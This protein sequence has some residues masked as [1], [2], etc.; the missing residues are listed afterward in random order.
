MNAI[1]LYNELRKTINSPASSTR[2]LVSKTG[3]WRC[4]DE[5]EFW[6]SPDGGVCLGGTSLGTRVIDCIDPDTAFIFTATIDL[7]TASGTVIAVN[8]TLDDQQ[9]YNNRMCSEANPQN[10]PWIEVNPV[11]S[12]TEN[13]PIGGQMTL[14]MTN[15]IASLKIGDAVKIIADSGVVISANIVSKNNTTK[16]VVLDATVDL[17]SETNAKLTTCCGLYFQDIIDRI[18]EETGGASD[19]EGDFDG[20]CLHSVFELSD[21][22]VANS[23]HPMIDGRLLR[24]GTAGTRASLSDGAANQEIVFTSLVLNAFGND[25]S[26][27]ILNVA[28]TAVTV[29][30]SWSDIKIS[31][32]NNS[33]TATVNDI[34]AA[35][36]A[37]PSAR[38]LVQ[39]TTGGGDGSG[40]A[41]ALAE[42]NLAGGANDATYDYAELLDENGDR[43][44][45]SLN[46]RPDQ[47]QRLSSPFADTEWMHVDYKC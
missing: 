27:E 9:A 12:F 45:I 44:I 40:L 19:C 8:K 11:V 39:V 30:G 16:E 21:I 20:D 24:R 38:R 22:M 13:D 33:G 14:I 23:S 7:T 4:G 26:V 1:R 42:T 36:H 34:I 15:S 2:Q 31:V 43:T 10:M 32:N 18:H 17:T 5:I 28:G 37:D 29:S 46:I 41:A 25:L 47:H 3:C 35:I 6:D